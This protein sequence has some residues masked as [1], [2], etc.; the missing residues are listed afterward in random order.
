MTHG[1]GLC[2]RSVNRT[3]VTENEN[4]HTSGTFD[5]FAAR[6]SDFVSEAVFFLG[7]V[8]LVVVWPESGRPVDL[9]R[10][11]PGVCEQESQPES[12]HL[13]SL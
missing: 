12:R 2:T 1:A 10:H 6:A 9:G 5:R 4:M 8:L 11:Y 3:D 7:C 13:G